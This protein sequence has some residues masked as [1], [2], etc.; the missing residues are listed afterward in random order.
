[1]IK[2][3]NWICAVLAALT[4]AGNT[5]AADGD[6]AMFGLKWGMSPGLVKSLGATL[7]KTKSDR[8]LETYK[9]TTL[10]KSLSGFDAY[11][12]IF[13]DGKLAKVTAVGSD[14]TNDPTGS[15]GKE[16]FES[17]TSALTE[18]YGRPGKGLQS[19]GNRL[20]KEYDEFFECLAYSGCGAWNSIY[21]TADK[22]I[23]VE[24][25]GQR[26]GSGYLVLTVESTPQWSNA[27][28]V[29]KARKQ[30][31]DKDAL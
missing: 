26:R 22:D 18:K 3:K 31:A 27:L 10:P 24:I 17:L 9:A 29:Y 12:L 28:D 6:D 1:M 25:K 7:T 8:N 11:I 5:Y 23:V 2:V 14:I 21:E 19:V 30:S 4:F 16:R 15:N 13:A 20:Y